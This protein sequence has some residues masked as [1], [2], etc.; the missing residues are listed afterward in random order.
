M[1]GYQPQQHFRPWCFPQ[2]NALDDKC[3]SVR[4]GQNRG[5]APGPQETVEFR[6]KKNHLPVP[7]NRDPEVYDIQFIT[8]SP[9]TTCW[10]YLHCTDKLTQCCSEHCS[11]QTG[12][13][14]YGLPSF[15]IMMSRIFGI[16]QEFLATH[17]EIKEQAKQLRFLPKNNKPCCFL[18][19]WPF[20]CFGSEFV[21]LGVF[22]WA[23]CK[24]YN[25]LSLPPSNLKQGQN[26]CG[27]WKA[28]R[29]V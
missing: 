17:T 28:P 5:C 26:T 24:P 19:R 15:V 27:N 25:F 14:V 8:C 12:R 29:I 3:N 21:S 9:E 7:C 6:F 10:E 4:T 23:H 22:F 13:W 2:N 11:I 20:L 1:Q 16:Q 18:V